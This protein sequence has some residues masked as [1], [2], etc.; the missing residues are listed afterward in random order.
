VLE[1]LLVRDRTHVRAHLLLHSLAWKEDRMRD[2]VRHAVDAARVAADDAE[3]LVLVVS[4]LLQVGE[5]ALARECLQRPSLDRVEHPD[6][7]WRMAAFLYYLGD[8]PAAMQVFER[9]R[10]AGADSQEFRSDFAC[11]LSIVGRLQEAET[12]FEICAAMRTTV[13]RV[14]VE[15]ARLRRQTPEHNHLPLLDRQ[16]ALAASGSLDQAGIEFARYK[17]LED[18]GRYPEAWNALAHANDVMAARTRYDA[19]LQERLYD[20]LRKVFPADFARAADFAQTGPMPIFVIGMPRSGTTLI[21][22]ILGNHSQVRSAGELEDFDRQLRC[23]AGRCT[24]EMLDEQIIGRLPDLDYAEL[25]GRYLAQTQWNACG[26][27]YYV[28]KLPANWRLV[29]IIRRAL[30]RARIL[31]MVRDPMD[32]CFSNFRALFADAN[33]WTYQLSNIAH[34]YGE[35]RKLMAHWHAVMPGE[36]LDV[37]YADLVHDPES[38]AREAFSFCGLDYEEGCVDL[39][40]NTAPIATQSLAQVRGGIH[41]GAFDEWRTYETQLA[42]LRLALTGV[43]LIGVD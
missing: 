7:L 2:S 23:V 20:R 25:G 8:H 29:G 35:Y 14:Y 21:E 24:Q 26:K 22:R 36:I 11:Q 39:R 28:D 3:L 9:A 27:A 19:A 17:E 1:A 18:L 32:V 38:T 10:A 42:G 5:C 15:L 30:P 37:S 34:C 41:Q 6:L 13:G 33:G 43:G 31:N 16:L 12:E 40:R 4:A